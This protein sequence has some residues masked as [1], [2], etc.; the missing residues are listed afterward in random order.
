LKRGEW[1]F[2]IKGNFGGETKR[3][4]FSLNSFWRGNKKRKRGKRGTLFAGMREEKKKVAP[5]W[6]SQKKTKKINVLTSSTKEKKKGN[7]SS[8]QQEEW[9]KEGNRC[10]S[11][12]SN[13]NAEERQGKKGL[14]H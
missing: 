5:I 6:G 11:W 14:C 4:I 1:F 9:K 10:S 8:V 3:E 2:P 13:E 12:F 7:N